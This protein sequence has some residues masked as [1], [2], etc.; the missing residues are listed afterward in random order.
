MVL[1]LVDVPTQQGECIDDD[2]VVERV[3]CALG[4]AGASVARAPDSPYHAVV[5]ERD[6]LRVK[7]GKLAESLQ[8]LEARTGGDGGSGGGA[9]AAEGTSTTTECAINPKHGHT[10]Y[11]QNQNRMLRAE[12]ADLQAQLSES[13]QFK[14]EMVDTVAAL[15]EKL[16]GLADEILYTSHEND[17]VPLYLPG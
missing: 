8:F 16:R 17:D 15:Q 13:E 11:M 12:V 5:G 3:R 10:L 7:C 9:A 1:V 4:A 6:A 14:A 2:A